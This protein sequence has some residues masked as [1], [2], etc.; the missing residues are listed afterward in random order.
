MKFYKD[1]NQ[2]KNYFDPEASKVMEGLISGRKSIVEVADVV[3]FVADDS[4]E[5]RKFHE[6]HNHRKSDSRVKWRVAICKEFEDMK[7]KALL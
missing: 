2:L 7:S 3:F 1:M 4:G 6:T 5:Q